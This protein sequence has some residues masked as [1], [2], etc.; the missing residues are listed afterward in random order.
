M[1]LYLFEDSHGDNYYVA[2]TDLVSALRAYH[3]AFAI[4][5]EPAYSRRISCDVHFVVD[6][7]EGEPFSQRGVQQPLTR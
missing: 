2:A 1:E 7:A 6:I 3:D 4:E 5:E